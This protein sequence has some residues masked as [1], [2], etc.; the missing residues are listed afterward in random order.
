[1]WNLLS[2]AMHSLS[3]DRQCRTLQRGSCCVSLSMPPLETCVP[4]RSIR[5]TFLSACSSVSSASEM[6][7]PDKS[8]SLSR[9]S[10]LRSCS[11][12]AT[13]F[14]FAV[15]GKSPNQS[16]RKS[17]KSPVISH[18]LMR[19]RS[20][21]SPAPD[22]FVEDTSSSIKGGKSASGSIAESSTGQSLR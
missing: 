5:S 13:R 4:R 18:E 21:A 15:A 9:P 1:M 17:A 20:S 11:W 10:S 2:V 3:S 12:R 14:H 22:T 16:V 7:V 19:L 6:F 8:I